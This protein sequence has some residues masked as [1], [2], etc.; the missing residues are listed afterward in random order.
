MLPLAPQCPQE[1]PLSCDA[2]GGKTAHPHFQVNNGIIALSAYN[3]EN[4]KSR[5]YRVVHV[6]GF[7]FYLDANLT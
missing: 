5:V 7:L 4:I 1:L 6:Q 2:S 3:I